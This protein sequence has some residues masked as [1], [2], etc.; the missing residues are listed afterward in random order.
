MAHHH[1][2]VLVAHGLFGDIWRANPTKVTSDNY[3]FQE[4]LQ[5]NPQAAW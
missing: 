3:D 4:T 1:Y 2:F 5:I